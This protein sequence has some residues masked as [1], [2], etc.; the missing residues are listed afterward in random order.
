M[1]I[2][3][4]Y[5]PGEFESSK[6]SHLKAPYQKSLDVIKGLGYE[7]EDYLHYFPAFAGHLTLI[8]YLTLYEG[9]KQV[10]DVSGHIAELGMYKGACSLLFAKLVKIFEPNALTQVH[11]FDWFRGS[12]GLNEK[13]SE[14][15][16]EDAYCESL[17]R[18]QSLVTA[19]SL[20]N[21]LKIHDMDLASEEIEA[22][23]NTYPHLYF[24]LVFI[25]A[26]IEKVLRRCLPLFW[27]RL[28]KGGMVIFDHYSFDLA[29]DEAPIIQE[30]L[31]DIEIRAF[32]NGWM[33]VGY[34]IK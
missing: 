25:D 13:E 9:Y 23:F 31:P 21:I 29:P 3:T 28:T 5:S 22:F 12:E 14:H 32:P 19:Q 34:A 30:I 1:N 20:D 17:D 6:F 11:G 10:L 15:I 18:V 24:K 2:K 27:N 26:G 33:P 4:D 7:T 8:R 16:S